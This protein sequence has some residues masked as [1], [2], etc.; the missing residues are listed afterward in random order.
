MQTFMP[1]HSFMA[2]ARSLDMRRLGKQRVEVKQLLLALGVP[3]GDHAPSPLKHW[4]NHPAAKMWRGYEAALA[5]YGVRICEEWRLRGYQDTLEA[6]FL[7]IG[8]GAYTMPPWMDSGDFH[9]SHQS[10]L[11]RK[12]PA[13]YGPQFPGVPNDLPYIWPV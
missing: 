7:K 5:H 13:F 6:Q 3:V 10:N 8:F 12:D 2:S 11:I 9:R 1:H 4:A